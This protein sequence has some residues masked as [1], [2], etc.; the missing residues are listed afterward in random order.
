[1]NRKAGFANAVVVGA[2]AMS[3]GTSASAADL[4]RRPPPPVVVPV[5]PWTGFYVGA[6]IGGVSSSE[7]VD[8][9]GSTDPSGVTGGLQAGYNWQVAPAW[10]VGVEG[11]LSWTN[12]SGSVPGAFQSNHNWYDTFDARLGYIL[13]WH[14]WMVYGKAGAAWMNADYNEIGILSVN[15]TRSGWNVGIGAEYLIAPHW[16]VKAEYNYLDFG[17]DNIPALGVGVDTQV[18]QFKVG[19]NYHFMSGPLFG[20]W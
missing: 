10:L 13:P 17:K 9:T 1:V 4:P 14:G 18:N 20:R 11:E 19:V 2:L 8:F 7:T 12:A 3:F 6:H 16:S 15:E 5:S